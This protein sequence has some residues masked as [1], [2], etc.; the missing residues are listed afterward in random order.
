MLILPNR[1][2]LIRVVMYNHTYLLTSK[3]IKM[4]TQT[5]YIVDLNKNK[6][7]VILNSCAKVSIS[8]AENKIKNIPQPSSHLCNSYLYLWFGLI[9][10]NVAI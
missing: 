8:T 2:K 3:K 6:Q 1:D 4:D 9:R 10:V 5:I 7:Y